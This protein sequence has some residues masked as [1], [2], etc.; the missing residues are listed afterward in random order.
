MNKHI[1]LYLFFLIS[2]VSYAQDLTAI[3]NKVKEGYNFWLYRPTG[4]NVDSTSKPLVVFLHGA[5]LCGRNLDRV[6]RYGTLDALDRGRKIDAFV[7]APQNPGGS[8][9]PENIMNVVNWVA[10]NYQVD[11]NRIYVLG[12]SLGGY[13]TIDFCLRYPDKIAA[14][15]AI[16]GGGT[17]KD[18]EPLN[19][20]PLWILHG[21]AD[22]AVHISQSDRIVES[23]MK[24]SDAPRLLYTRLKGLDHGAPARIFYLKE[25]YDWLFSHSLFD[26]DRPVN[27][28]YKITPESIRAAY[29]DL[30]RK[31]HLT[32][33]S[34]QESL[35]SESSQKEESEAIRNVKND[36]LYYKVKSGDNLSTI[37]K[38]NHTTVS[39]IK[40]LNNLKSDKLSIGQR[41]RI[42]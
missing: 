16:C 25:T 39:S 9:K 38:R 22:R 4:W 13:G 21:T 18:F 7:V 23:M 29:S 11:P 19:K 40:K 32:V 14:A 41:L 3:R 20:M 2:C 8:W 1:L 34:A 35:R 28:S 10:A 15:M 6:R 42:R 27:K 17:G 31:G 24:N 5:S 12:M 26:V 33:S 30:S 37:A 36:E